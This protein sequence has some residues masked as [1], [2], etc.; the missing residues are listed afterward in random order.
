MS[1]GLAFAAAGGWLIF[2]VIILLFM[3]GATR[4]ATRR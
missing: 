1:T 2:V 3:A 4:K